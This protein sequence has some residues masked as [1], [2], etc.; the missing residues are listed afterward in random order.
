[1]AH[2][3]D[4]VSFK[5]AQ[6]KRGLKTRSMLK[7]EADFV[8]LPI[9]KLPVDPY[10]RVRPEVMD[11]MIFGYFKEAEAYSGCRVFLTPYP[12]WST[13][14]LWLKIANRGRVGLKYLGWYAKFWQELFRLIW[15][16]PF[17]YLFSYFEGCCKILAR[18]VKHRM[19]CHWRGAKSSPRK[20]HVLLPQISSNEWRCAPVCPRVWRL[21]KK[22]WWLNIK[23]K[24]TIIVKTM[25]YQRS[26]GNRQKLALV[27][28]SNRY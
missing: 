17:I 19:M 14:T 26:K 27:V 16:F 28:G 6:M 13:V 4:V 5:L 11:S 22:N 8:K 18:K 3:G 1:M 25:V 15:R 20:Y 10:K 7:R 21:S 23:N 12:V 2:Q 24:Y 9:Q